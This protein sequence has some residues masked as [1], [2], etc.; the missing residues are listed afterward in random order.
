MLN[1]E[2][3]DIEDTNLSEIGSDADKAC[4]QAAAQLE[5]NWEGAGTVPGI[6]IWRIENKRNKDGTPNFGINR[7][8]KRKYGK[9]YR[10][11]SYIVLKTTEVEDSKLIW[12]VFFWIGGESTQDEYGVAAYKANELD[13]LLGGAPVQHREVEG[14]ESKEFIPGCFKKGV[15]YMNGGIESGFRSTADEKLKEE[16]AIQKRLFRLRKD[17]KILRASEVKCKWKYLY[18]GDSFVLDT[19]ND[20]YTWFGNEC[21]PFE[22]NKAANFVTELEVDRVRCKAHCDISTEELWELLG[23]GDFKNAPEIPASTSDDEK[24]EEKFTVKAWGIYD[25][26]LWT[27]IKEV[28][29]KLTSLDS[30]K[31]DQAYVIDTGKIVYAWIGSNASRSESKSAMKH[32]TNYLKIMKKPMYTGIVRCLQGQEAFCGFNGNVFG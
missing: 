25:G 26:L 23:E 28:K 31:D 10:G 11:D 21:S 12:D 19:G 9:F 27:K 13:D 22:K 24:E 32:A 1:G 18:H 16:Q 17:G 20:I 14:H 7:W 29:E 5:V 15:T 4:K 3:I 2:P 30:L 8:P 6:E